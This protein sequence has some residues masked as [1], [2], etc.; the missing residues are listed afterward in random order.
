[1][2]L[3]G[4]VDLDHASIGAH[5]RKAAGDQYVQKSTI[6]MIPGPVAVSYHPGFDRQAFKIVYR[7]IFGSDPSCNQG[8][9]KA[10]G[11]SEQEVEFRQLRDTFNGWGV[12]F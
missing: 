4:E 9:L 6:S 8:L 1:M 3:G 2:P 12:D 5:C 11:I 10:R 7:D